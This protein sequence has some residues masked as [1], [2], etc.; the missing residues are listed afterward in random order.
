MTV[1]KKRIVILISGRGSN[2]KAII[3]AVACGDLPLEIRAVISDNPSAAGL[4]SAGKS[5]IVTRI[6]DP[7]QFESRDRY[8]AE[9]KILIDDFA[10]DLVVLAGFMRILGPDF[11]NAFANR[12]INIHPALLP[13]FPG[14]DTHAR[15]LADG[16]K[17]HGASVHFVTTEVD[18]GPVIVQA[19]VQV[20]PGDTAETLAARVLEQEHRIYSLAIGW[21][22][23]DRLTLRDGKVLL[24]GAIRPEQ[25][26][27]QG[28]SVKKANSNE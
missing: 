21:F 20:Q 13:A 19:A 3:D 5:G 26:L 17:Q 2:M 12:L 8:D 18:N 14:L 6:L 16:V 9:L 7:K 24:D 28:A 27:T 25:G 23:A 15:A 11:V 10:P 4:I 1:P 22:V